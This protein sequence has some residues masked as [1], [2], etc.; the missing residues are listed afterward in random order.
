MRIRL[1][2]LYNFDAKG[3]RGCQVEVLPFLRVF[4]PGKRYYHRQGWIF[5]FGWLLWTVMI[6]TY[7][8]EA[9]S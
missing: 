6:F 2:P 3:L 8:A 5:H 9:R 4:P 1:E 7:H